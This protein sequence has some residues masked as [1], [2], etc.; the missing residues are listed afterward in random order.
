MP[1]TLVVE[2]GTGRADA[3]TF[4]SRADATARMAAIPWA[5]AWATLDGEEQDQRLVEASAWLSRLR[6]HGQRA[7]PTQALAWPRAWMTTPDGDAISAT[8][9]PAVV[10]DATV[11]LA[12]ALASQTDSPYSATGLEPGTELAVGPVRLTPAAGAALPADVAALVGPYTASRAT[13][14]RA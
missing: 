10:L 13:L 14:A 4:L 12:L 8:T 2:D 6:W 7:T 1:L 3:N 5:A 9:V 11:R